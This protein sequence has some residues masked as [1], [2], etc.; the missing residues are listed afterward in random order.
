MEEFAL[1]CVKTDIT[2]NWRF[3]YFCMCMA[4]AIF[5]VRKLRNSIK[6][7]RLKY[8]IFNTV[9]PN[10]VL[11]GCWECLIEI[12]C[13]YSRETND[14]TKVRLDSAIIVL[15]SRRQQTK[16]TKNDLKVFV[17]FQKNYSRFG[18]TKTRE[19]AQSILKTIKRYHSVFTNVQ[20]TTSVIW[21]LA[22]RL[23]GIRIVLEF[24]VFI[25]SEA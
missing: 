17:R 21:P 15:D 19:I 3:I 1:I 20:Y 22:T 11:N 12:R 24:H 7:I 9:L 6:N 8:K 23:W 13:L 25:S 5:F 4:Y 2:R 16:I 10:S 14:H 18:T